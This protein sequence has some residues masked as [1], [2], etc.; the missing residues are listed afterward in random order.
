M[1]ISIER[2]GTTHDELGEG[3]VWDVEEQALYWLDSEQA[4]IFRL[5]PD[6]GDF[7]SWKVPSR[8]GSMAL[9]KNGGA[10]LALE[11]GFHLFDFKTGKAAQIIDP[12][13]NEVL[14]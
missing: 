5:T 14:R 12:E 13:P 10:V 1:A 6:S 7:K 8:I 9:R 4:E 3:P 11:T 2:V